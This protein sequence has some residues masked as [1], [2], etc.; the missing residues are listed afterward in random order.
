MV[1]KVRPLKFESPASGGTQTDTFPTETNPAEDYISTKGIALEGQDGRTIDL[2]SNGDI[3]FKDAT[4]TSGR[5]LKSITDQIGTKADKTTTVSAGA[6]LTGGGDLSANRTISMPDVGTAGSYGTADKVN[7][8]TTDSKGRVTGVTPTLISIIASQISNFATAVLG[9]L[10]AGLSL[11]TATDVVATDSV[12]VAFGKI[13]AILNAMRASVTP[14]STGTANNA[15][16]STA[17][18][19]SDH[20]HDTLLKYF[21]TSSQAQFVSTNTGFAVITGFILTPNIAG[22]YIVDYDCV[23][24]VSA[25]NSI[26]RAQVF[27]NGTAQADSISEITGRSGALDILSGGTLVQ[28]NGTTDSIDVRVQTTAGTI[29]I[30]NRRLRMIRVGP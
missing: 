21:R 19:K 20:V 15:G 2:D 13:Q 4:N 30:T 16:T 9:T 5:T 14:Q 26:Q 7:F 10:L 18:A 17:M 11:A 27:K 1:D 12:L 3:R 25:N 8:L 22:S 28:M 23:S 24:S 6:G 29:T